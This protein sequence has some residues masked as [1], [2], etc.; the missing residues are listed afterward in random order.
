[1]NKRNIVKL[2]RLVNVLSEYLRAHFYSISAIKSPADAHLLWGPIHARRALGIGAK[3]FSL[4]SLAEV[5]KSTWR[6]YLVNEPLKARYAAITSK[7][8]RQLADDK[9]LF[10]EHCCRHDIPTAPILA[11]ITAHP[12]EVA[13]IPRVYSAEALA[14]ILKPGDY[15]IKPSNGSHGQG[16]FS[17]SVTGTGLRWQGREGTIEAFFYYCVEALKHARALILQPKLSNHGQIRNITHAKGLSTIRVVTVRKSGSIEIIGAAL[18]IVVGDSE[19]DNLSHGASGNLVA[20]VDVNSGKLVTAIGSKT[21]QWPH[22]IDVFAHPRS[23]Q[24]ILG[25][26]LPYWPETVALVKY[27][28]ATIDSLH[29]VGWDIAITEHGPLIVEANWRYDIDILQVAYK[30]GYRKIIEDNIAC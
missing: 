30:K 28:H 27:A 21:R 22:M 19:V 10:F 5:P 15:F 7:E 25:L 9:A 12:S 8:A 4:Y 18:R 13:T 17:L 3:N 2:S 24:Q 26:Q 14:E 29:T 6:D 11:L 23:G 1:M 20:G 16:T